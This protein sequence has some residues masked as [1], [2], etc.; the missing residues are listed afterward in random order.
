MADAAIVNRMAQY[1]NQPI[2]NEASIVNPQSPM[3]RA[4]TA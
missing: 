1:C 2:V 4:A 3:D